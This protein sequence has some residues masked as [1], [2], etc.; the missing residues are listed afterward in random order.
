MLNEVIDDDKLKKSNKVCGHSSY[1]KFVL[2][3][4]ENIVD[5]EVQKG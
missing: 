5:A 4:W 3:S 2:A 1:H